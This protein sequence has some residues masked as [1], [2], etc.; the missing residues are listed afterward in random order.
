MLFHLILTLQYKVTRLRPF[1]LKNSWSLLF[2]FLLHP[3]A[4][5]QR[6]VGYDQGLGVCSPMMENHKEKAPLKSNS[7]QGTGSSQLALDVRCEQEVTG[8]PEVYEQ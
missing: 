2:V 1:K 6:R 8:L 4:L 5:L 7:V 3:C